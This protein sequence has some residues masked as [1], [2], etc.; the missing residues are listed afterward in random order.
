MLE[1]RRTK[2]RSKSTKTSESWAEREN[3]RWKEKKLK[4]SCDIFLKASTNSTHTLMD[5]NTHTHTKV[6][7]SW[8]MLNSSSFYKRED[9]SSALLGFWVHSDF[10][11][12]QTFRFSVL[13]DL[14]MSASQDQLWYW[15][16]GFLPP[17]AL[18]VL[19]VCSCSSSRRMSQ[20]AFKDVIDSFW[21]STHTAF[22]FRAFLP[23][24][25]KDSSALQTSDF[26]E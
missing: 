22:V 15:H 5:V 26:H 7:I 9:S 6:F 24:S 18:N 8:P 19:I 10:W 14:S 3:L 25:L 11:C 2:H 1:R 16:L 4:Y 20:E 17:T 12:H 13:L 21:G 23:L